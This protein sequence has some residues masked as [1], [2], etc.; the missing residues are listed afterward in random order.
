M[1]HAQAARWTLSIGYA[2]VYDSYDQ[3]TGIFK[4]PGGHAAIASAGRQWRWR[5][6]GF[7]GTGLP[8]FVIE[9]GLHAATR[10]FPADGTHVNVKVITGLEWTIGPGRPDEWSIGL[11][12]PHFSNANLF[13]RNAGY[14]GLAL[15]FGRRLRF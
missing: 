13:S 9:L 14:D 1:L 7:A 3:A 8:E 12:W 5:M 11:M 15:R 10:P 2:R 6:P 4:N